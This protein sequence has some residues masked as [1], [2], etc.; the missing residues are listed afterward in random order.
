MHRS[1]PRVGG[2]FNLA[3]AKVNKA[4]PL[5]VSFNDS[6]E[7]DGKE[8]VRRLNMPG[9]WCNKSRT[10]RLVTLSS[11][12]GCLQWMSAF[13][14]HVLWADRQG[15]HAAGPTPSTGR[16]GVLQRQLCRPSG[17][18]TSE[19]KIMQDNELFEFQFHLIWN[20]TLIVK[21]VL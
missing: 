1:S 13:A 14:R 10:L 19:A 9:Q 16:S 4:H 8:C 17:K 12:P 6:G 11:I 20:I 3:A 5:R 15:L 21:R 18:E 2:Q 7:R